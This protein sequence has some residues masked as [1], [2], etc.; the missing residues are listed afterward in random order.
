MK[1]AGQFE[2]TRLGKE[3]KM[4]VHQLAL[5]DYVRSCNY[6]VNWEKVRLMAKEH[7][8]MI[9]CIRQVI[10]IKKVRPHTINK[11]EG[12]HDLLRSTPDG[13]R[14]HHYNHPVAQL[15]MSTDNATRG[16]GTK[17]WIK[18]FC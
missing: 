3:L 8:G 6:T 2:Y 13:F 18:T 11:D 9:C 15:H 14:L 17:G 7:N 10:E 1:D 5:A 4:S 12:C 16:C